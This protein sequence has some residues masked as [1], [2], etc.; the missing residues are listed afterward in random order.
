M[1]QPSETVSDA[2]TL[3]EQSRASEAE[4]RAESLFTLCGDSESERSLDVNSKTSE[5]TKCVGFN[6]ILTK[7]LNKLKT[8][9]E[10]KDTVAELSEDTKRI[11]FNRIL[12][13][14]NKS[15]TSSEKGEA[16]ENF[17]VIDNRLRP[18]T[19]VL[20]A[21]KILVRFFS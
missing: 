8:S 4:Q 1:H 11:G 7:I 14:F 2:E 3:T 13:V 5:N 16:V 12:K 19:S 10:T 20:S 17:D 15:K 6:K 21:V 18:L 9:S